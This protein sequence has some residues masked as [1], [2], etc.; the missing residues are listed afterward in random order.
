V[1]AP[2]LPSPEKLRLDDYF[3][4]IQETALQD[5]RLLA[6]AGGGMGVFLLIAPIVEALS[7]ALAGSLARDGQTPWRGFVERYFTKY[8]S[9][10]ERFAGI[11]SGYRSRGLH[12]LSG[13]GVA[14][15]RGE[16]D[17]SLHLENADGYLRLHMETLIGH[18]ERVFDDFRIEAVNDPEIGRTALAHFDEAPPVGAYDRNRAAV[19][20]WASAPFALRGTPVYSASVG[21]PTSH[22]S[23]SEMVSR[24]LK[25]EEQVVDSEGEGPS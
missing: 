12:N 5:A 21:A 6:D 23:S 13:E 8:D 4:R 15:L 17:A 16:L 24:I 25:P 10:Y 3:G 20:S 11:Y 19:P 18:V 9:R 1:A 14:F 7:R 22:V 2:P